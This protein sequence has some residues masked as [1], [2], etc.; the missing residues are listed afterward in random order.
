MAEPKQG[1]IR[2]GGLRA[3][4][5]ALPA[6]T[7]D[8]MGRRGFV[9][10]RLML[11]WPAVVG[12]ALGRHSM[13]ERLQRGRGPV[14]GQLLVLVES[15]FALE[16]QHLAPL[17]VDRVNGYFGYQAISGLKLRQGRIPM[18]P[19]KRRR[20]PPPLSAAAQVELQ[21]RLSGIGDPELKA[22]LDRLGRAVLAAPRRPRG[23]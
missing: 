8:V 16:L 19:T 15:A 9:E 3:I 18:T 6:A 2:R 1:E 10:A 5:A 23:P 22:A 13:P 4:G 11:D 14:P 7:R 17:V 20:R 21:E 12:E